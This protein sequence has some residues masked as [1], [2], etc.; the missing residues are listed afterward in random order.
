[1]RRRNGLLRRS[2]NDL[3]GAVLRSRLSLGFL[4][5]W[6]VMLAFQVL[7]FALQPNTQEMVR[8][9]VVHR[10]RAAA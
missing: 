7:L 9:S 8:L 2:E 6:F 1:M 4:A 5:C 10:F 3:L